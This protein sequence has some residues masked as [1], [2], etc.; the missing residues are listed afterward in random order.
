MVF[1]CILLYKF[2]RYDLTGYIRLAIKLNILNHMIILASTDYSY[3]WY[4][5]LRVIK[6]SILSKQ[7]HVF[8]CLISNMA[9]R[10]S[11]FVD[12]HVCMFNMIF[13]LWMVT[14]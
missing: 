9:P 7:F 2:T 1:V 14:E 5:S 13:C 6:F 3:N 10:F 11:I 12:L 8:W 4:Q